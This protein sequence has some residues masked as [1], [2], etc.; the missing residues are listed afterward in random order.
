MRVVG[1]KKLLH[2]KESGS[3]IEPF[4]ESMLNPLL[5]MRLSVTESAC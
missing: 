1:P 5:N 2:P 3:L 4:P